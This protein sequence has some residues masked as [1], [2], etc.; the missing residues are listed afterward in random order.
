MMPIIK[1]E[2]MTAEA[3]APFGQLLPAREVGDGRVELIEELQNLRDHRKAAFELGG[4]RAEGV[5]ADRGRNGAAHFL[6]AGLR[7]V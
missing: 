3:F 2:P 1:L 5:A 7:A 4:G 6:V